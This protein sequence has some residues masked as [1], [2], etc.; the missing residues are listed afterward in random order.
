MSGVPPFP[1]RRF[2]VAEYHQM[3]QAGILTEDDPVEL[4]EGWIVP[5]M[6]R[7]PVHDAIIQVIDDVVSRSLPAG[8][9]VRV[10]SAIT[11]S[12]SEPEPDL[13]VVRGDGR[14][15]LQRH[16]GPGD[17]GT[18]M[19]VADTTLSQDRQDKGRI[20]ARAAIPIYWI[21]NL[22]DLHIEVYT[23]PTGPDASARYR[24][25]QDYGPN[26]TIPLVLDSQEVARIP[27]QELLP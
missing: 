11:T 15:Y 20:Y 9:D 3:I 25:R 1:I 12:E 22:I 23:D 14:T 19:E 7:K 16:P 18:L 13:A 17:I 27:V 5:K 10:Q 8:W 2:S 6:P 4:L 24:S 26:D 21:V